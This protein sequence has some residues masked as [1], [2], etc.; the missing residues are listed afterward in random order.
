MKLEPQ[1][2]A[3]VLG[4]DLTMAKPS[5]VML[6]KCQTRGSPAPHRFLTKVVLE[7]SFFFFVGRLAGDYPG[8]SVR[9]GPSGTRL[10]EQGFALTTSGQVPS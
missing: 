8:F 7:K 6:I 3:V 9:V 1:P 4:N 2:A 5:F 10:V